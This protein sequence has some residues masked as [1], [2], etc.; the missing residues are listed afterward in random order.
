VLTHS[1]QLTDADLV[2]NAASKSQKHLLAIAQRLKL[3]EAV[4]DVLVERG[5]RRVVRK[6]TKNKG[7]LFSLAGYGKLTNRARYDRELTLALGQRSDIPRQYFLKLLE[8]ASASV[9]AKLEAAHP[10]AAAAIQDT[11]DDVAAAM[12]RDVRES[13]HAF[14]VAARDARRRYG[15]HAVTEANVHASARAQ[16]FERTVVA[17]AR[18]GRFPIDL[19]E[20]ALLDEGEDMIL[21]FAKAADCSWITFKELLLMYNARRNLQPDDVTRLFEKYK[22]LG[23]G[24][25]SKVVNF[26]ERRQKLRAQAKADSSEK[27]VAKASRSRGLTRVAQR[28]TAYSGQP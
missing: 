13:S 9:R 16:E 4:T 28:S 12:Q 25:A 19:V 21:I 1:R 27:P 2:E 6:V 7:A 23:Q 20:R 17:L 18:L 22:K 15:E 11:V 8:T 14:T 3:S 26:H 24:T 5:N 10:Q